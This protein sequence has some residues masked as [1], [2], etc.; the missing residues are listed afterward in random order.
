MVIQA[1]RGVTTNGLSKLL[2]AVEEEFVVTSTI[3][4]SMKL[5]SEFDI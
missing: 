1:L 2:E 5:N 3:E 4:F